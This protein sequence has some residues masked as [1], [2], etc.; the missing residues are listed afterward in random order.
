MGFAPASLEL[1][2]ADATR[3]LGEGDCKVCSPWTPTKE[4]MRHPTR[5]RIRHQGESSLGSIR[6]RNNKNKEEDIPEEYRDCLSP[7]LLGMEVRDNNSSDE[8]RKKIKRRKTE[9][10][11]IRAAGHQRT[12]AFPDEAMEAES[13]GRGDGGNA[14]IVKGIKCK[15]MEVSGRERGVRV[16]RW[17][18]ATLLRACGPPSRIRVLFPFTHLVLPLWSLGGDGLRAFRFLPRPTEKRV[19]SRCARGESRASTRTS[20]RRTVG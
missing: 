11:T 19:E 13:E 7:D 16:S 3:E 2:A 1:L 10:E 5:G 9:M 18:L 8:R 17:G 15:G 20:A 4:V 6:P 14:A 12:T